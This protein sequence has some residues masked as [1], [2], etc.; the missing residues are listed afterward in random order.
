MNHRTAAL[1]VQS[2][3]TKEEARAFIESKVSI[4]PITGCW[5]W[6]LAINPDGYGWA[7]MRG[8]KQH[9]LAHRVAYEA[10][11]GPIPKGLQIDHVC[12]NRWCVN[13]SHLDP[14]TQTENFERGIRARG[15]DTHCRRGHEFTPENTR[16]QGKAGMWR[17]CATCRRVAKAA[18]RAA[19]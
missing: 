7:R 2:S 5:M 11:V 3:W 1:P 17:V 6:M 13:P 8:L 9:R 16:R 15:E 4:V 10:F 14:V 12:R 18:W 19:R